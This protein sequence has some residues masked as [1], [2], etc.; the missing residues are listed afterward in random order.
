MLNV[1][2]LEN[3]RKLASSNPFHAQEVIPK[4]VRDTVNNVLDLSS[5]MYTLHVT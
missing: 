5:K 4:V 2:S 3:M 1:K